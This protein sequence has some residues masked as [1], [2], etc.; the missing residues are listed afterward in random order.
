MYYVWNLSNSLLI[1]TYYNEVKGAHL[2][3]LIWCEE[4]TLFCSNTRGRSVPIGVKKTLC[5]YMIEPQS[6]FSLTDAMTAFLFC[7]RNT[8]MKPLYRRDRS[9]TSRSAAS[10]LKLATRSLEYIMDVW[11]KI[12]LRSA[13]P[14][15]ANIHVSGLHFT[16]PLRQALNPSLPLLPLPLL[17]RLPAI[18]DGKSGLFFSIS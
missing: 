16:S 11:A 13:L 7:D 8:I 18:G 6:F 10:C 12:F 5:H 1:S 9:N 17:L 14:H 2:C 3:F 15:Q 4:D